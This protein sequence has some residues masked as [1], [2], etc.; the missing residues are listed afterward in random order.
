ME[1]VERFFNYVK[2]DTMSIPGAEGQPS[3]KG[4]LELAKMLVKEMKELGISDA[5]VTER[6]YIYGSIPASAGYERAPAIG[7]I[8]HMDT[9]PDASGKDVRPLLHPN[10]NGESVTLPNGHVI[11]A[12][13]FSKL[14]ELKG[15][16]LI[17]ASGD[18]L[19]GADDKAG[20]AEVMTVCEKLIKGG[21]P[22]GKVCVAFTP[23]E[24][25]GLGASHFDV[26]GFGAKFAY[27][28]D[29]GPIEELEYESFN[30]A[31]ATL[32]FEG[33]SVHPGSAK[34]LMVNAAR[35]A[36]EF[37]TL[38][39][40]DQRPEKTEGREGFFHLIGLSGSVENA[41]AVYI[42]RDHSREKF[43]SQKEVVKAAAK[44]MEKRH[45]EG[46]V[47]LTIEDS[48][49]NMGEVIE[50][51]LHLVEN[52]QEAIRSVGLSPVVKPI[53]GGTDGSQLS[54]MG[55]PCPNIGTGG[56]YFHGPNECITV[57]SMEK[58][59]DI[60]LHVL[61][62]YSRPEMANAH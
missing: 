35:L 15:Q 19:L 1:A 2:V 48:Y 23:D 37:D 11:D 21:L 30:A 16:T 55:L 50:Q 28:V 9:S 14:K 13:R 5:R 12:E 6:G 20:I 51:H 17:T 7:L 22:H 8:S 59:V 62:L 56:L 40:A 42:L 57:E 31:T 43:E 32:D 25:I 3:S 54:F 29:G 52:A 36:A 27:T 58:A 44:E 10:F 46:C 4:Q 18:T 41:K 61:E 33:V 24:E 45:G 34:G 39:P 47:R 53:R 26:E 49:F 38:L 60:V